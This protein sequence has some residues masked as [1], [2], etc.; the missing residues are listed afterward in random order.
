[1]VGAEGA[2]VSV[3]ESHSWPLIL[4]LACNLSLT[5]CIGFLYK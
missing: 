4:L 1:M 5:F 3:G 2:L